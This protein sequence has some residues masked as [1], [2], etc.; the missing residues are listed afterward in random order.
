MS[1]HAPDHRRSI[2]QAKMVSGRYAGAAWRVFLTGIFEHPARIGQR[3]QSGAPQ[4]YG[5]RQ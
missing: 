5:G 3:Y 1:D 2:G 4:W